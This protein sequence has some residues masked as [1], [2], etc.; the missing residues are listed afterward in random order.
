MK[1]VKMS[2]VAA[3]LVGASAYA[4]DN[5]KVNGKAQLN[6]QTVDSNMF[7]NEAS[8][9]DI[10][11]HLGVT[12]DLSEG[13]SAGV[14]M[15]AVTTLGLENNLV[16]STWSSARTTTTDGNANVGVSA[17]DANY[18]DEAWIAGTAMDT[19]AKLG[20]QALDTPL[21][22]TEEW[23]VDRNTFEAAVLINNSLEDTT[24]VAAWV[25][26]S[27]GLADDLNRTTTNH[28]IANAGYMSTNGKFNTFAKDGAYVL[29]VINNSFK[30]VTAQAWYY[31]LPN[32]ARAYWLQADFTED[33][34]LAGAQYANVAQIAP[35]TTSS[36]DTNVYAVMA[37]Y[38]MKDVATFKAAFSEVSEDGSLMVANI[39]TN[40]AA[41]SSNAGVGQSKLYTEM[42]WN[43]GSVSA[44][45][46]TSW[47][48]TA[49][50]TV[51]DVDVVAGY[52]N[53][54]INPIG[55]AN[56]SA[57]DELYIVGTKSFGPLDASIAAIFA[58]TTASASTA[59][60]ESATLQAYLTYNF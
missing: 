26:K 37:G 31:S 35:S 45:G 56:D 28:A 20:R 16:G 12:A 44:V 54:D 25:G 58:E 18:I 7:T 41:P 50:T 33:G 27:N 59:T 29:G 51:S 38:E 57:V 23:G 15:T 1:L 21:A 46:A 24:F 49:E 48:L 17:D 32:M 8:A 34:I 6:Y 13:V 2:M 42:W 22:F 14:S 47:S 36:R 5:V 9:A 4:I 10:G 30:P 39:A 19:T 11:L 52:V 55:T 40:G 3:L 53:C 60:T 43:Y